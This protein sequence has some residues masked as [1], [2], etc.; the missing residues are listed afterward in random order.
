M[1]MV[2]VACA[3]IAFINKEG[4]FRTIEVADAYWSVSG[5][6]V[7]RARVGELVT[8][9]V[10]L[11]ARQRFAGEID[12]TIKANIRFWFDK[13]VALQRLRLDLQ[14]MEVKEMKLDFRPTAASSGSS[15]GYHIDVG[16]GFPWGAWTMPNAYPPRLVVS[17]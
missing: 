9:H 7:E 10:L 16:F 14:S 17:S 11:R 15:A 3:G 2:L 12:I 13:S 1:R 8:G 4:L 6:K 5:S